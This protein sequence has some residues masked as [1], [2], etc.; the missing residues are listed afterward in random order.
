MASLQQRI[1][2]NFLK[3][4]T[5]S[6]AVDSVKIAQLEQLL[7]EGKKLKAEDLVKIFSSSFDELIT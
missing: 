5:E 2:E 7:S 6:K 1:V 4:L 3:K